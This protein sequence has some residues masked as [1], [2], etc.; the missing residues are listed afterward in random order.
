[1]PRN[2][3]EAQAARAAGTGPRRG[4][5]LRDGSFLLAGLRSEVRQALSLGGECRW[6]LAWSLVC[7][8]WRL[9]LARQ[10]WCKSDGSLVPEGRARLPHRPP[11]IAQALSRPV[12]VLPQPTW[13]LTFPEPPLPPFLSLLQVLATGLLGELPLHP[14]VTPR[15]P[16]LSSVSGPR[17]LSECSLPG[18]GFHVTRGR[19]AG[20]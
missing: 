9:R 8:Q 19:G 5:E 2:T 13:L 1:M 4:Q 15:A 12:C 20:P 16:W 6:P 14:E 3:D 17:G 11:P 18:S 7:S 10:P